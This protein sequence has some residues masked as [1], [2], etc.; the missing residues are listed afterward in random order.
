MWT[1]Y[2]LKTHYKVGNMQKLTWQHILE[3]IVARTHLQR[4]KGASPYD[5]PGVRQNY[6]VWEISAGISEDIQIEEILQT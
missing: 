5:T 3:Q 2:C 1:L 6:L 4:Q